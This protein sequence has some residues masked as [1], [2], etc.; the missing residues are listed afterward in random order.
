[1]YACRHG[2]HPLSTAMVVGAVPVLLTLLT[3]APVLAEDGRG[4]SFCSELGV[5]A[6]RP[7]RCVSPLSLADGPNGLDH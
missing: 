2:R 5:P 3:A 6:G 4:T 7:R 1:M